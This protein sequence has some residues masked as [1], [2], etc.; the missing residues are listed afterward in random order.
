MF[1]LLPARL[2]IVAVSVASQGL[3]KV[4]TMRSKIERFEED[5]AALSRFYNIESSP[6][7]RERLKVLYAAE[8][9]GLPALRFDVLDRDSQVDYLL[10]KNHLEAGARKL[11]DDAKA[12]AKGARLM[13]FATI[14]IRLEESRQ[15][16]KPVDGKATALDMVAIEKAVSDVR[17]AIDKGLKIDTPTAFRAAKT[18]E[19]LRR[20]F[21]H[22]FGFYK[23]YDPLFTWWVEEPFRKADKALE[24]IAP[25]I[26]EK[27][28]GVRPGDKDTIVGDPIG[29][30]ALLNALAAEHVPYTPEELIDIAE[31]EFAWCDSEMLK[32]SQALGFGNDWHKALEHVKN[33]YVEP[34]KQ[35]EMIRN[36][37]L[38]AIDYVKKHDLITVPP[39]AEQTWR[40]EMMSP[41]R[42][43][44]NP[45]FL[46][47]EV[48]QVSFPTNTM[49]SEQK[50]M[51]MRGNNIHFSRATV[52]HELIP[53]HHLQGYYES[54]FHPYRSMF[55]TPFWVEGWSLYW[56]FMLWDKGFV[57]TPENKIGALFW[58]M[59]RCARIIFSLK[60]HLGQMSPQQ[61]I[62]FLVERVG[63][64]RSTAEGEVRRS[65]N[66][67]YSPLYQ[68]AYMLGA[69]Q[70]RALRHELV[71]SG[72]MPEKEFHDRFLQANQMPIAY[73]R[74]L[75][76]DTK[77]TPD[78]DPAWR[79]YGK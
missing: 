47:G 64:E 38:E 21:D 5:R 56:E 27:L 78:Y 63:H 9:K 60:F 34:G 66:G 40:M 48:I 37:A 20:H 24:D 7:R 53:G 67:D 57:A 8:L 68:A 43:K 69:F 2:L 70:I 31:K 15:Q 65:F 6:T 26:R 39:I 36:L 42:Q 18:I 28:C 74:A 11:D 29:R 50:L 79:F 17:V 72:K 32:A 59:H 49:D 61:C 41:E 77:L 14:V 13:P 33:L 10:F 1:G 58:R 23:G 76:T 35:P 71:D 52:H 54:R 4:E 30:E 46:G 45:F 19:Q 51:S 75:L 12:D 44:V 73:M 25:Y 16:M 22:W 3:Q 55:R 62:D